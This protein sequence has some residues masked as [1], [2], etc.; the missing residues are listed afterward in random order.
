M[1]HAVRFTSNVPIGHTLQI[2][3]EAT[4][5]IVPG[6]H[7]V[8]AVAPYS[9]WVP[10]GQAAQDGA[11]RREVADRRNLPATHSLQFGEPEIEV[12]PGGH[13]SH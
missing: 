4:D 12:L 6:S 8:Q 7:D 3:E 2:A 1:R 5:A 11:P 10:G 9:E 13:V